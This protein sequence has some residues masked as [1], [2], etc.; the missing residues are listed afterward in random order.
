MTLNI[1]H[2]EHQSRQSITLSKSAPYQIFAAQ[3]KEL[4]IDEIGS[5][6]FRMYTLP[7]TSEIS[8]EKLRLTEDTF[9]QFKEDKFSVGGPNLVLYVSNRDSTPTK[10][11]L[12]VQESL[13]KLSLEMRN[14]QTASEDSKTLKS[15]RSGIS[16]DDNKSLFC[17]ER[18][19]WECKLCECFPPVPTR[20]TSLKGAHLYNIQELTKVANENRRSVL[21]SLDLDT[22]NNT[23]NILTLCVCCHSYFDAQRVGIDPTSERWMITTSVAKMKSSTERLYEEF[24]NK[25]VQFQHR[26][27][28]RLL[29]HRY[30]R[31]TAEV[32]S[33]DLVNMTV[34]A[35]ITQ[36]S[37]Q[38]RRR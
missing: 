18:D 37:K 34:E 7:C 4:F 21:Q 1:R 3:A 19:D 32:Y 25:P 22:I 27:S 6:D 24:H 17:K 8:D 26:P 33:Q 30:M 14:M 15:S 35:A 10:L 9:A 28:M 11:P 31:F 5:C 36:T 16:R 12:L 38:R 20:T 2:W 29:C 23:V 13:A